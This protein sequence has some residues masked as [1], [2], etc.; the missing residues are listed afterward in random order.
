MNEHSFLRYDSAGSV[1]IMDSTETAE[2]NSFTDS[3]LEVEIDSHKLKIPIE[4]KL[5]N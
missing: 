5:E 3:Y 1:L 2:K 4:A